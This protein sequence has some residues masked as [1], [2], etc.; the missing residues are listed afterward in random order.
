MKVIILDADMR[1]PNIHQ[2]LNLSNLA[3]L[4]DLFL[5]SELNLNSTLQDTKIKNLQVVTAGRILPNPTELLGSD[6]MAVILEKLQESSNIVIIDTPSIL[7]ITDAAVL[8]PHV[9]G[10]LLVVKAGKTNLPAVSQVVSQ[11]RLLGIR[12]VGLVVNDVEN[13]S[14]RYG[15][16]YRSHYNSDRKYADTNSDGQYRKKQSIFRSINLHRVFPKS[17]HPRK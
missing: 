2:V 7:S 1:Q 14:T 3:G 16:F 15:Y 17:N 11:M 6:R 5:Q 8:N 9:D 12:L 10:S 13:K 4:S